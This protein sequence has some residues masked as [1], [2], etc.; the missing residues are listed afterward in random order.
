MTGSVILPIKALATNALTVGAALGLLV[1]VFQD[2]R[3]TRLL[4][5]AGQDGSSRPTSSFSPQ[6]VFG[7]FTDYAVSLLTRIKELTIAACPTAKPSSPARS[8]PGAS[9]PPGRFWLPSRSV[10]SPPHTSRSS[11]SSA[12]APPSPA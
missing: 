9:S 7:H 6:I 10:P 8:A 4:G 5:Y 3:L 2:G 1:R 12:S 11:R